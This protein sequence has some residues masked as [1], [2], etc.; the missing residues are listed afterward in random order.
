MEVFKYAVKF[1]DQEPADTVHAFLTLR[2]KRLV[3]SAGAFRG[4]VVPEALTDEPLEDLPFVTLFYRYLHGSGYT[5]R[6][7]GGG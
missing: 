3:A 2:G 5:L 6:G 7:S 4:V 1:S